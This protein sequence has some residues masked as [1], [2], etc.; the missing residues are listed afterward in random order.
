MI[1]KKYRCGSLY[2]TFSDPDENR[3]GYAVL[4]RHG[5]F[6]LGMWVD[7]FEYN[8]FMQRYSKKP[9]FECLTVTDLPFG[10]YPPQHCPELLEP[11]DSLQEAKE[12]HAKLTAHNPTAIPSNVSTFH[13]L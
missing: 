5:K 7:G 12:Y 11:F 4:E 10:S 3:K 1:D 6:Y 9:K 2:I 13:N 8:E